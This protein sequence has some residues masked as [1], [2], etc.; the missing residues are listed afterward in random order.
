MLSQ[1]QALALA[2][3]IDNVDDPAHAPQVSRLLE[4]FIENNPNILYVTAV[5]KAAKGPTAG[6][7]SADHDPFVD[8]ALKRAF[9]LSIQGFDSMFNL[10]ALG[11]KSTPALVMSIPLLSDGQSGDVC[12]SRVA[13]RIEGRIRDASVRERTVYIVNKHGQ[14][15]AFPDTVDFVPGRDV[16]LHI[17][18]RQADWRIAQGIARHTNHKFFRPL[19]PTNA[20]PW[21]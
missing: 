18:A 21:K 9:T 16:T 12:G 11:K 19:A 8:A 13:D 14:V 3:W 20:I 1:R 4:D 2:G 6:S 17:A 5:S 7:I 15:V 10:S